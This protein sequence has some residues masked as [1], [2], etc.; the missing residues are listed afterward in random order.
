MTVT[1]IL[2]VIFWLHT[3]SFHQV[4]V[5]TYKD[6]LYRHC[7]VVGDGVSQTSLLLEAGFANIFIYLG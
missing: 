7:T 1:R 5:V 3:A 2:I 4:T 6:Y